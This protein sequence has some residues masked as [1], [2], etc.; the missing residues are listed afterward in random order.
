MGDEHIE[1]R[2]EARRQ[3]EQAFFD[4]A[5]RFR[6]ASD[7]EEVKRLGDQLGRLVFGDE[8]TRNDGM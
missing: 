4:L 2:I 5:G 1:Q 7:P 6:A 3:K 8:S